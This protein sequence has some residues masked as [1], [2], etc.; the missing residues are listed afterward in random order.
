MRGW[1][2]EARRLAAIAAAGLAAGCA[3][4]P[5][6]AVTTE[7]RAPKPQ[8]PVYLQADVLGL[9]SAALDALL[10]PAKL[11]RREGAGEF[12]RYAFAGC[13]LIVI[14]YPDETGSPAV[15]QLDAAA[16]N[17]GEEKPDLDLCLAGGPAPAN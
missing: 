15:R 2:I 11:T 4:I 10:G 5:G 12:R 17:S 13:E 7:V 6:A 1:K 9:D 8:K 3:T 14:L 16:K